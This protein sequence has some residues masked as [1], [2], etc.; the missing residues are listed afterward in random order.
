MT[1]DDTECVSVCWHTISFVT[2]WYVLFN[3]VVVYTACRRELAALPPPCVPAPPTEPADV[4]LGR[5]VHNVR[6]R[7]V[8][9]DDVEVIAKDLARATQTTP[10]EALE[11]CARVAD[12][13]F[14]T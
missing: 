8:A 3:N 11:F 10:P 2:T 4:R 9:G 7:L 13:S 12:E 14:R 5:F 6:V 1:A